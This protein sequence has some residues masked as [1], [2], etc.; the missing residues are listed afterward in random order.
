MNNL[1][2]PQKIAAQALGFLIGFV[3]LYFGGFFR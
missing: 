2:R 1:T 3:I